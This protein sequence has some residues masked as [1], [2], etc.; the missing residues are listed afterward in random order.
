MNFW[1]GGEAMVKKIRTMVREIGKR[2]ERTYG[3]YRNFLY[4]DWT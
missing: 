3:D 2:Q 4:L 1:D